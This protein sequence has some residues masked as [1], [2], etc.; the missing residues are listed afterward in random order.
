MIYSGGDKGLEKV[1]Q[2]V[3]NNPKKHMYDISNS[4]HLLNFPNSYGLTPLYVATLN[5]HLD[6]RYVFYLRIYR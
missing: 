4:N 5:G 1:K 3:E 6:V 2:M